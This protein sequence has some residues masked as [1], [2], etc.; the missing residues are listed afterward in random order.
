MQGACLCD[1]TCRCGA[2]ICKEQVNS[3]S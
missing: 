3:M 2:D 1:A